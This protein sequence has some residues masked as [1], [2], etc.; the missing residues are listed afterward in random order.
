[1]HHPLS[2]AGGLP[3]ATSPKKAAVEALLRPDP[4]P[5]DDSSPRGERS[6]YAGSAKGSPDQP[7]S[8]VDLSA[9]TALSPRGGSPGG[10][11]AAAA[12]AGPQGSPAA[13]C[14]HCTFIHTRRHRCRSTGVYRRAVQAGTTVLFHL[15]SGAGDRPLGV[16]PPSPGAPWLVHVHARPRICSVHFEPP[17]GHGSSSRRQTVLGGQR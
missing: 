10:P 16:P 1:M 7:G 12:W 3:Q 8:P 5:A 13:W 14:A 2:H 9:G 11:G 17:P 15:G 4:P 6:V